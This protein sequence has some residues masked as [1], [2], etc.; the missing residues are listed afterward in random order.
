MRQ[1]EHAHLVSKRPDLDANYVGAIA[2]IANDWKKN[3]LGQQIEELTD[4][5]LGYQFYRKDG[6]KWIRRLN[7]DNP[8]T[9]QLTVEN[10]LIVVANK[11]ADKLTG[12]AK[13][14]H[15]TLVSAGVRHID[16]GSTIKYLTKEGE[17]FAKIDGNALSIKI[18]HGNGWATQSNTEIAQAVYNSVKTER[19]IYRLGT[20]NRSLAGEAQFWSAENPYS[21]EDIW[22]YADKYGIPHENLLGDEVFFE[23][24][25]IPENIPFITREAPGFGD[26][27]GGAIEVVVPEKSITLET[28]STVKFEK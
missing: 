22:S 11:Y 8:K 12:V 5:P 17:E 16:D 2:D 15:Q 7:A 9:P 24:G 3:A 6:N 13:G 18:P 20:L 21:Y 27:A 1:T 4:A 26:N 10:G 23:V 25:I 14:T 28:F 19:K